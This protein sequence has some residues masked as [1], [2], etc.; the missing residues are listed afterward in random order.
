MYL[1]R[2]PS[3]GSSAGF[4]LSEIWIQK[5]IGAWMSRR[6]VDL[7]SVEQTSMLN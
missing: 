1:V 7:F 5:S 6:C 2:Q 4:K 3:G